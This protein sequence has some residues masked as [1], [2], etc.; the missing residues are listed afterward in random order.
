[1][2]AVRSYR[3]IAVLYIP[4]EGDPFSEERKR[5]LERLK[6]LYT[7]LKRSC[8]DFRYQQDGLFG[9]ELRFDGC[10]VDL[11]PERGDIYELAAG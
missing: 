9:V 11:P 4:H 6:E 5:E 8:R 10:D 3:I 1:M 2:R 7:T